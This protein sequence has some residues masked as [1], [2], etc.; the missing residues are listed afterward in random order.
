MN[1]LKLYQYK[2]CSTCKK[3]AQWLSRHGLEYQQL[4]IRETPPKEE[5]LK[6]MLKS[7]EGNIKRLLNTSGQDY[8]K[9]GLKDTI[10]TLSESDVLALLEKNG[11]LIKR[12]F[13]ISKDVSLVGFKEDEWK[14]ALL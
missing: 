8:R 6:Q 1:N 11:N 2:A 12:P 10:A 7:Y 13:L 9:M 4:P 14:K 5:E 3:A